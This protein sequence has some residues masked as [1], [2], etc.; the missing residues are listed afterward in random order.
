MSDD[1]PVATTETAILG[2]GCFWCLEAVFRAMDGVLAVRSGYAGGQME[3]PSYRQ[4]CG[5]DTG[6]A[7]VVEVVFDPARLDYS[8]LLD[9]FFTIHDPTTLDRQGNDIG[10]QYRSVIFATTA[11]QLELA[12]RRVAGL[13]ADNHFGRPVVTAVQPAPRFWPAEVEHHDYYARNGHEPYCQYVI[14]PKLAKLRARFPAL[15]AAANG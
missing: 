2:G 10:S 8:T 11:E 12:R 4:V 3:S 5:G 15:C 9:V 13:N 6:H 1:K 7:E 14:A